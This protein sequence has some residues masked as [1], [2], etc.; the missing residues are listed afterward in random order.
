LRGW[1]VIGLSSFCLSCS[2]PY[3]F[4]GRSDQIKV[5]HAKHIK[6]SVDC[7]TCH[8]AV[9]DAKTLSTPG[10]LPTQETCKQCHQKAF[11]S[12]NCGMC[13]TDSA[14]PMT[15]F[16]IDRHLK[17]DHASHIPLVKEDCTVCHKSLPE[18]GHTYSP[19]TMASCLGCHVHQEDFNAGRC[20]RC[21]V[22]LSHYPDDPV[23]AFSHRG[24]WIHLHA[25]AARSTTE[26]CST[27]HD[28]TYCSTCHNAGTAPAPVETLFPERVDR[29]FQIH[30][31]DW[32][33]RHGLEAQS[34][35]TSCKRCHGAPFCSTCH[36][37]NNLTPAGT[38]PYNP[39]P[40]N[41]AY[42]GPNSHAQAARADIVACQACH[43]QGAA[44]NCVSCHKVG[45][46]GGNPHP[47]GFL[48]HHNLQE[49]NHNS[50]CLYCH[51]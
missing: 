26:S 46:I 44:S 51:L 48:A 15:Y 30:R 18:P 39:H 21:H 4:G 47:S 14:K 33:S 38:N 16:T 50:M 23:S 32:L 20:D 24:D 37:Q 34:D 7:P 1:T 8:D 12:G 9:W 40:P 13:H 29:D 19:P 17:F 43:D 35:E 28:A 22:D 6:A 42:P 3:A 27:C 2:A 49:V 25:T 10:V 11:D 36:T 41:W 5:P 31:G 45:G